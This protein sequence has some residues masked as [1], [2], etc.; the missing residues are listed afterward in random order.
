MVSSGKDE[1]ARSVRLPLLFPIGLRYCG[2]AGES[3]AH[4]QGLAE[5]RRGEADMGSRPL[6]AGAQ[7]IHFLAQPV[8]A[9][10]C[11]LEL[12]L[13][14]PP[15]FS[16]RQV[17]DGGRETVDPVA[18]HAFLAD[19]PGNSRFEHLRDAAELLA[20]AFHLVHQHL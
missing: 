5:L 19:R 18:A 12:I 10:A 20:N 1:T 11:V 6:Q 2:S 16:A 8:L 14:G 15:Q 7:A 4:R 13:N 9:K 17:P 3:Q